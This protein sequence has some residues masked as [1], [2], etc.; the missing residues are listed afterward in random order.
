MYNFYSIKAFLETDFTN[1]KER[2][3]TF[4]IP[5]DWTE[6]NPSIRLLKEK[7]LLDF[8][9]CNLEWWITREMIQDKLCCS[10][11]ISLAAARA[12]DFFEHPDET[13]FVTKDPV[14]ATLANKYFGEDSIILL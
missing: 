1:C 5:A 14:S 4:K 2:V 7:G 9:D 6:D 11:A 12:Y 13:V 8:F 3:I 10:E